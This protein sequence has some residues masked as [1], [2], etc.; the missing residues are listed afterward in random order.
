MRRRKKL[1]FCLCVLLV[2]LS[3]CLKETTL[4]VKASFDHQIE[5]AN[6]TTPVVVEI[7]NTSTGADFYEWIFEGGSPSESR[8]K[9]PGKITFSVPGEHRMMLRAWNDTKEEISEKTIRVDSTVSVGFGYQ[10][11]VNDFAPA[12]VKMTNTTKGASSY[13]WAFEGGTP[14]TSTLANPGVIRFADEGKHRISLKAYNGSEYFETEKTFVLL[15]LLTSDFSIAPIL[16]DRDMEAPLTAVVKNLSQNYLSLRWQCDGG[17]IQNATSDETTIRFKQPGTYTVSLLTDNLKEQHTVSKQITVKESCGIHT[18]KEIH[19]G[20]SEA[21]NTVGC[22]F[23][24]DWQRVLLSSEIRDDQVGESIDVGF[25]ALN[26]AFDHCY[27][28]SPDRAREAA[29]VPIPGATKTRVQ[30]LP[31]SGNQL[32]EDGFQQIAK[33]TDMDA[34]DFAEGNHADFFVLDKLPLF[35]FLQTEDGRRGIIY[36]KEAI[37][38]GASSYIVTDIKIE[39]KE[40]E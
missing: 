2:A 37:R 15:P 1:G 27:F 34:F 13:E 8:E 36:L 16:S 33:A 25:F 30:N 20:I 26:S 4:S 21:K 38:S 7:T 22:F 28:F 31:G 10:V 3:A 23:A 12:T 39:K 18:F 11:L 9:N 24:A 35:I 32:S 6:Q 5:G 29:F 40:D 17:I 14:A 19:F